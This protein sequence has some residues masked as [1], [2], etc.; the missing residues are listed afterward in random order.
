MG[1]SIDAQSMKLYAD[2]KGEDSAGGGT[3][4]PGNGYGGNIT[5]SA[6]FGGSITVAGDLTVEATGIGGNMK[7]GSTQGGD[8]YGGSTD[9][10]A[11]D[12]TIDVT[13]S[14]SVD[15]GGA[16]VAPFTETYDNRHRRRRPR[17]LCK[18]SQRRG[19]RQDHSGRV[20]PPLRRWQ[21]RRRADRRGR[22]WW[23]RQRLCRRRI[24]RS[25]R[26]FPGVRAGLWWSGKLR[27]QR[28]RRIWPGWP[29]VDRGACLS[30][31]RRVCPTPR[32][33]HRR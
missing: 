16:G 8:G 28:R 1:G 23:H 10:L 15:A 30:D 27:L 32:G 7:A 11:D 20:H 5:I 24:D 12:G 2:G 18:S 31:Q 25:R 9:M 6:E 17:R 19:R 3:G 21:R 26:L 22:L 14:L 13:G 4:I 29:G 33:D